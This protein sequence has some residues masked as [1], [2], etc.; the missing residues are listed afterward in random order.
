MNETTTAKEVMTM[1]PCIILEV[2]GATD[3]QLRRGGKAI[4][5]DR[6]PTM[7]QPDRA[8]AESEALRLSDKQ[9]N[10][11]FAIFEASALVQ[12]TTIPT[13]ATFGGAIVMQKSIPALIAIDRPDDLPF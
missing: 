3:W 9:P 6:A 12:R 8:A 7:L 13:H 11:V 1:T 5:T 2:S 10:G 4:P